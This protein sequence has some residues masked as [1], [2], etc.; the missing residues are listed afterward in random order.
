LGN[1]EYLA[2]FESIP[3]TLPHLGLSNR[4]TL[5]PCIVLTYDTGL[6]TDDDIDSLDVSVTPP[7][8]LR[9]LPNV[10]PVKPAQTAEEKEEK[11]EDKIEGKCSLS[12]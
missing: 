10:E 7:A 5:T 2:F 11:K 1:H 8:H 3:P 6:H 9:G 12:R 4:V